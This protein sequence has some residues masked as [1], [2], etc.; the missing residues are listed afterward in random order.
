MKDKKLPLCI[1]MNC[2]VLVKNVGRKDEQEVVTLRGGG[3]LGTKEI[4]TM[5]EADIGNFPT[6]KLLQMSRGYWV[7][8]R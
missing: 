3:L 1:S 8:R 6:D 7:E 4:M 5:E 2:Q